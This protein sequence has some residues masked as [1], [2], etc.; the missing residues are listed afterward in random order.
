MTDQ[1][2]LGLDRIKKELKPKEGE[3]LFFYCAPNI[4][5]EAEKI[6]AGSGIVVTVIPFMMTNTWLIS[7]IEI[8]NLEFY[9]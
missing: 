8:N 5:E 2:L 1:I 4:K 7:A 6:L 3:T 9:I